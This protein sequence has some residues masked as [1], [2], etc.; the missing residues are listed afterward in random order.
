MH[1]LLLPNGSHIILCVVFISFDVGLAFIFAFFFKKLFSV[2]RDVW[3]CVI[4]WNGF[5]FIITQPICEVFYAEIFF[6]FVKFLTKVLIVLVDS[7]FI[8]GFSCVCVFVCFGGFCYV[9]GFL[10]SGIYFI[11]TFL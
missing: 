1:N 2:C 11:W 7:C 5:S 6:F 10:L 3:E 4:R 8:T 9:K